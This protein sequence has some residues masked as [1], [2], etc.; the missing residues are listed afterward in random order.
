LVY[1]TIEMKAVI[2]FYRLAG[3]RYKIQTY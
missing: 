3:L 2:D 1:N